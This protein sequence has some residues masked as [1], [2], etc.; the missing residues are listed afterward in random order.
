MRIHPAKT[1]LAVAAV[2]A[3]AT[4]SILWL[5]PF[6]LR[7]VEVSNPPCVV[8]MESTQTTIDS[9]WASNS[10]SLTIREPENCAYEL[11]NASIQ[12]F[13]G[14]LFVRTR[15]YSPSG[16]ATGCHCIHITEAR[17]SGIP[18][19]DYRVHVYSWP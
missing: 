5:T 14:H 18:K 19:R 16:I 12:R 8:D 15:Y 1:M 11:R 2:V 10:L 17:V 6:A 9:A 3:A 13:G 7:E 4:I